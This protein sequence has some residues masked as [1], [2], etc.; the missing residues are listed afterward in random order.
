MTT[1]QKNDTVRINKLSI[2]G[3]ITDIL[4][5]KLII[6]L[7]TFAEI[8][9]LKTAPIIVYINPDDNSY[10][11]EIVNTLQKKIADD[12]WIDKD[13]E[14]YLDNGY[15]KANIY[16]KLREERNKKLFNTD[17]RIV[18]DFP[19]PSEEVKQSWVTYRQALR[20]LPANAEPSLN[21]NG[22]LINITWPTPPS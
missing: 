5:D 4:D 20:D 12:D 22:E 18:A 11:I 1:Y 16:P 8:E 15:N 2:T 13:G 14:H 10:D 7:N 17:C 6:Q 9:S 19:H 3:I 21:E